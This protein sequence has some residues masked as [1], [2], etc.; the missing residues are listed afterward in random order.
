MAVDAELVSRILPYA[1]ALRL[2]CL[3]QNLMCMLLD[4]VL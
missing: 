4:A 2:P 1:L 3:A